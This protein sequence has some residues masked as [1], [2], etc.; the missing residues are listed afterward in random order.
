MDWPSLLAGLLSPT[1]SARSRLRHVRRRIDTDFEHPW[2]GLELARQA[3]V[4]REQ[5]IRAFRREYG[6]TPHRYLVARRLEAARTLIE[7]GEANVTEA[8]FEVG[9]S[10]LGAF[11]TAFRRHHGMPPSA[12]RKRPYLTMP[13]DLITPLTI[14]TCFLRRFFGR[15]GASSQGPVRSL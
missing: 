9:F 1:D 10:S 6:I 2:T 11:S 13:D 4:S 5:L 14:P 12:T 15:V 8:C 3:G 7:R